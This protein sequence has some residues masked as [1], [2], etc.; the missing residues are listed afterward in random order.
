MSFIIHGVHQWPWVLSAGG[1]SP[2]KISPRLSVDSRS[3]FPY[4]APPQE[5]GAW[6][7]GPTETAHKGATLGMKRSECRGVGGGVGWFSPDVCQLHVCC[8]GPAVFPSLANK[9]TETQMV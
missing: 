5:R 3:V 7:A 1:E 6:W 9:A 4:L 8:V 2:G